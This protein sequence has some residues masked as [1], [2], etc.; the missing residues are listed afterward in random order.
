MRS[1]RGNRGGLEFNQ[2]GIETAVVRCYHCAETSSVSARAMTAAC[3]HCRKSL[4]VPDIRIKGYHWGG[5]LTSC[6]RVSIGRKAD[7][8]C[9]LAVGS[10]GADVLGRFTGVLISGGPVTIGSRAYFKGAVWAPSLRIEPGAVVGG[11][12]FVIPCNPLGS[13]T[14][15]GN[16]TQVPPPPAQSD[17]Q[18]A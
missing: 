9:T 18:T 10:L 8:T 6:G 1:S 4:E 15:T 17:R 5:I 16:R 11:G 7:V 13:I 14:L 3:E 2:L 12:P